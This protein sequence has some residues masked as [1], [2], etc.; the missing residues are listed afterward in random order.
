MRHALALA[1]F[2]LAAALPA[3]AQAIHGSVQGAVTDESGAAAAGA[4]VTVRNMDTGLAVAVESSHPD[5]Y[6]A[7][8]LRL[9]WSE[10]PRAGM[11]G[12]CFRCFNRPHCGEPAGRLGS[13]SF[14]PV[15]S[16]LAARALQ[17]ALEVWF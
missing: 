16:A 1:V 5:L 13:G 10:K 4:E 7:G 8:E 12:E 17:V 14:G 3:G 11:R 6:L 9:S 15:S 2:G